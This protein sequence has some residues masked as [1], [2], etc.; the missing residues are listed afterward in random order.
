VVG[1]ARP[2]QEH[3]AGGWGVEFPAEFTP[4]QRASRLQRVLV[5]VAGPLLWLVGVVVVG[6]VVHRAAAVE[7][8]LTV[9]AIAFLVSLPVAATARWLR[10]RE[11]LAAEER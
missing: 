8:G 2:Q 7:L 6:V 4:L 10:R 11:E 3:F 5:F 9:T 1:Q